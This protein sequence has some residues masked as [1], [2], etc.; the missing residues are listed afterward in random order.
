M[1]SRVC[2]WLPPPLLL[3]LQAARCAAPAPPTSAPTHPRVWVVKS[4]VCPVNG[5]CITSDNYPRSYGDDVTSGVPRDRFADGTE[6]HREYILGVCY[7]DGRGHASY[8]SCVGG[9]SPEQG[10]CGSNLH[11][12]RWAVRRDHIANGVSVPA[13]QS[14]NG[15]GYECSIRTSHG[16]PNVSSNR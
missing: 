10:A 5:R 15:S 11:W 12:I 14:F 3:A 8:R 7:F 2:V 13:R 4:G 9:S 6:Y 16:V 1:S